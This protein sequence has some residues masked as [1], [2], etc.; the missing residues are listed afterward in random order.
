MLYTHDII[1]LQHFFIDNLFKSPKNERAG[2]F[3]VNIISKTIVRTY[4]DRH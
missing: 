1:L 4:F 3:E 2:S